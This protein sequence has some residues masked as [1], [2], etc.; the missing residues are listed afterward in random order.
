MFL[1]K[2]QSDPHYFV[3]IV[4]T[5][6]LSIVLHELAHGWV[7]TWQ[8]DPT[9]KDKG[10]LTVDPRVHMGPVSLLLLLVAGMAY[11]LMPVDPSRFRSKY[12]EAMVAAAGPL[13][14]LLLAAVALSGLSI[15]IHVD[16]FAVTEPLMQANLQRFLWHF[17]VTNCAL[18]FLN[19]LPVPP[20][21]GSAILANFHPGYARMIR[22]VRDPRVFM[23]LLFGILILSGLSDFGLFEFAGR[24][25]IWF[26][27]TIWDAGLNLS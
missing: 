11:G 12:G 10:H 19:L 2:L 15:W 7:A 18:A 21:D 17:G 8:G 24:A 13:M 27:N 9:P 4:V 5:V 3:Y 1:T 6:V 20:L 14:N 16:T 22:S 25:S 23:Y 26:V